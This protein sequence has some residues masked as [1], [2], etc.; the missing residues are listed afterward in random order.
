VDGSSWFFFG[1]LKRGNIGKTPFSAK[2]RNLLL[3]VV[4]CQ[5]PLS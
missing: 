3:G 2:F 4:E 5:E 1:K